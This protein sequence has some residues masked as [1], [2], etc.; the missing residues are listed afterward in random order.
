MGYVGVE[1]ETGTLGSSYWFEGA[2]T[3]PAVGTDLKVRTL[4]GGTATF[5]F[6]GQISSCTP[7]E[8]IVNR[9]NVNTASTSDTAIAVT[10]CVDN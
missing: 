5:G 6:Q 7:G 8:A 3:A 2:G 4:V 9:V 10:E 1:N